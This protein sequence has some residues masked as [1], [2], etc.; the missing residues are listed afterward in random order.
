[1]EQ[2]LAYLERRCYALEQMGLEH[3]IVLA[4][5]PNLPDGVMK[6]LTR[7][8][9]EFYVRQSM[10]TQTA[11]TVDDLGINERTMDELQIRIRVSETFM[12]LHLLEG[13][14]CKIYV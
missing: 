9:L 6:S 1:M 8:E 2:A 5:E 11:L 10:G 12:L 13:F 3:G 7:Q 4:N 14:L